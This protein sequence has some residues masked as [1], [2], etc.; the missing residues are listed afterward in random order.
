MYYRG[1]RI[2]T[3][4]LRTYLRTGAYELEFRTGDVHRTVILSV[5]SR[6]AVNSLKVDMSS[7]AAA[8]DARKRAK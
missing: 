3:A 2:G 8:K 7:Q 1:K 5:T 6:K 4:P